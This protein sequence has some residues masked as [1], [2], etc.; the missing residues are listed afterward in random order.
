[1][2]TKIILVRHGETE[3][4]KIRRFQGVSDIPLNDRG[5]TQV[6][7]AQKALTDTPIDAAYAS[8]LSRAMETASIICRDRDLDIIPEPGFMEQ[9]VGLWEGL[10]YEEI[11][12]RWPGELDNWLSDPMAL[13]IP[14]GERFTDVQQR[15]VRAF[16]KIADAHPGQ[17]VLV[18][19]HMVCLST[20]LDHFAGLSL[21]HIWEHPIYNAGIN[22]IETESAG[23]SSDTD[24][25]SAG[26]L[27]ERPARILYWNYG[28]H[29]PEEERR[30]PRRRTR[31]DR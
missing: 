21:D 20:I 8:P 22:V 19:S 7:Y 9:N 3:W 13:R 1:M 24:T 15:A 6:G 28:D 14:E 23:E 18:A 2:T 12:S 25:S 16:W 30:Q 5:R 10:T 17:T 26:S 31:E 11:T 29:L 27:F 4:N